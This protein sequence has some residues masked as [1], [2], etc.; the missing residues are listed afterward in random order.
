MREILF[1]AHRIPFPP[2]RGDKIRSHNLLRRLSRIA[3]IHV[4]TFAEDDADLAEEVELAGLARSYRVVRRT[5]PLILAGLQSLVTG[6]PVSLRAFHDHALADYVRKV[7]RERDIGTIFIFSSQMGQ[8][9]PA[10]FTGRVVADFV[11]CDSLKFESYAKRRRGITWPIL[12]RE[13]RLMRHEEARIAARADVSLLISDEEAALFS[14]RLTSEERSRADVRVLRNGIDSVAFD[15]RE[16]LPEPGLDELPAPRLIFTGQMDYPPNVDA[17]VR[18]THQIMRL[19]RK[20]RP[21]ATFHVVGRNPG[22][23]VKAL[24]GVNG[25][26]VWGAVADIRPWLRG[27]DMALVPLNIGRGVQNKVLEAMAMALPAVLTTPAATGIP[28]ADGEEFV[29]ADSDADLAAAVLR[30]AR[31]K[32]GRQAIGQ[33]AR[34]FVVDRFSWAGALADLPQI[35]G[36]RR[37]AARDAG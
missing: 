9:V 10:D 25:T 20:I 29:I 8:Y 16:C 7:L 33:A 22:E 30:L 4:A 6:S 23:E 37:L 2:N 24:H 34:R 18:A 19:V 21:Q 27:A 35:V 12:T 17:V 32:D 15:P 11:D 31:D 1:L 5:K 3:P 26:R 13:G 28:A 14:E 36:A